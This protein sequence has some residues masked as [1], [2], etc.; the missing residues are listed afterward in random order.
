MSIFFTPHTHTHTRISTATTAALAI[1]AT[2]AAPTT[3]D[4]HGAE[5]PYITIVIVIVLN[6]RT[7]PEHR[8]RQQ[9]ASVR[10][11]ARRGQN[12]SKNRR[13][14]RAYSSDVHVLGSEREGL[15]GFRAAE[16][17]HELGDGRQM[18]L[19]ALEGLAGGAVQPHPGLEGFHL[20]HL[21]CRQA[22]T[23]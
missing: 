23:P 1:R 19:L 5:N 13:G 2:K 18:R 16:H 3:D 17:N 10:T 21:P 7:A 9:P 15:A 11:T 14:R 6:S 12:N 8:T 22:I 4:N 20:L